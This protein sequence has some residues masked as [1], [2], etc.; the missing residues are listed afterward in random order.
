[1]NEKTKQTIEDF[2]QTIIQDLHQFSYMKNR[3]EL[4]DSL[5]K[6]NEYKM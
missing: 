3:T 4:L 5:E 2:K 6:L 1:M